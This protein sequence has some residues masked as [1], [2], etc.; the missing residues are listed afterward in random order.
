M[1]YKRRTIIYR[2]IA[3]IVLLASLISALP[4]KT[5]AA[6]KPAHILVVYPEEADR[7]SGDDGPAALSRVIVSLGYECDYLEAENAA[8]HIKAAAD[9]VVPDLDHG[10][11]ARAIRMLLSE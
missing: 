6:D 5:E 7:I 2:L 8:E 1:K 10:G 3:A 9:H 11:A 4:A